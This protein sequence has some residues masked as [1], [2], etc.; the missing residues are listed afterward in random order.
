MLQ[1][2]QYRMFVWQG[3][4]T[5]QTRV[6]H[7]TAILLL[8]YFLDSHSFAWQFSSRISSAP[9]CRGFKFKTVALSF[10]VCDV[11]NIGFF[12]C[13]ICWF[14]SGYHFHVHCCCLLTLPVTLVVTGKIKHFIFRILF[15]CNQTFIFDCFQLPF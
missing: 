12:F 1:P 3:T 4:V 10:V 11:P 15:V 6:Q 9:Y 13:K 8:Q 2:P 7:T 14:L 5:V